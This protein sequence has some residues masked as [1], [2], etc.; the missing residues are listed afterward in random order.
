MTKQLANWQVNPIYTI[1]VV[2]ETTIS[3]F[4]M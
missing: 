4:H 2:W 1:A 3:T